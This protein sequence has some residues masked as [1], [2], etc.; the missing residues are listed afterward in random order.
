LLRKGSARARY[1]FR[2]VV[3]VSGSQAMKAGVEDLLGRLR[4]GAPDCATGHPSRSCALATSYSSPAIRPASARRA[5]KRRG[6]ARSHNDSAARC[7][8][9]CARR[10]APIAGSSARR[11][12]PSMPRRRNMVVSAL[13]RRRCLHRLRLKKPGV[14]ERGSLDRG[15]SAREPPVGCHGYC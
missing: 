7:V 15:S 13:L 8:D 2:L 9:C 4:R 6:P 3:G 12:A 1:R 14:V 10:R 11:F 5:T